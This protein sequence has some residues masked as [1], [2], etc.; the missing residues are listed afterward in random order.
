MPSLGKN[1]LSSG[2]GQSNLLDGNARELL[3]G[4][5]SLLPSPPVPTVGCKPWW[6]LYEVRAQ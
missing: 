4:G 3:T 2:K 6:Q 5:F 1:H